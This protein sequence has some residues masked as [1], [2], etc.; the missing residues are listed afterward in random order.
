[1]EERTEKKRSISAG[2]MAL[3]WLGIFLLNM[4]LGLVIQAYFVFDLSGDYDPLELANCPNGK[5]LN[6][7]SL[8]KY[9]GQYRI[10]GYVIGTSDGQEKLL[11]VERFCGYNNMFRNL[12]RNKVLSSDVDVI[13]DESPNRFYVQLAQNSGTLQVEIMSTH[14]IHEIGGARIVGERWELE[15]YFVFGLALTLVELFIFVQIRKIRKKASA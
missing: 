6:S 10:T 2:V 3:I 9:N 12:N 5:V 7:S 1:M 13:T 15:C 14:Y 4:A 11:F 8:L